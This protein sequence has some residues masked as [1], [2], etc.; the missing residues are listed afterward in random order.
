VN[1]VFINDNAHVNG[2]AAK[3]AIQ[4]AVGLADRG[5]KIYFVCAVEPIAQELTHPNISICC[6]QQDD[7]LANPNPAAAFVQGWWNTRA[8]QLTSRIVNRLK[9]SETIIHLHTWSRALSAS[10]IRAAIDSDIPVVCTLHDFMFACPSGTFFNHVQQ[11]VCH[12]RPLSAACLLTNCDTRTYAQK[13]YRVGRQVIQK[14]IGK[15]PAGISHFIVHSRLAGEVMSPYL[16]RD[17]T[18][19]SLP[20][21]VEGSQYPP[22]QP[23][24]NHNLVYLG[25]LVREKGVLLAANV[26]A[27][28]GIPLTF[29][30]SGPLAGQIQAACPD[31]IITGWV[32][33]A[34]SVQHLRQARALV[35]PSLWY[36]TL[37]L[38]VL[39]AA[40]HGIPSLV[41]DTSAAREIVLDGV[42]GLHFKTGD[43]L[44]LRAKMKQLQ[45]ADL[46]RSLGRGAYER[47]WSSD[48]CSLNA[49]LSSLGAIYQKVL[50]AQTIPDQSP[51]LPVEV[52]HVG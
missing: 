8:A 46:V 4:E 24:S 41:P 3:V 5:H 6:S 14:Q 38:V 27:A 34:A 50:S 12:L 20:I 30:G 15:A 13:L 23:A 52:Q 16:P 39:E 45:D 26:A 49:H 18:L 17:C 35:F 36:E 10:T 31:A 22:A 2:G 48:Y 47:F 32:D 7:L 42:T 1:V 19:H 40:A 51:V 9:G 28:E 33:R 11:Q 44:D 43:E 21:Y 29:V 37:G 25:R